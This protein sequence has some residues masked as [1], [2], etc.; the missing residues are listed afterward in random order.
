MVRSKVAAL[1]YAAAS[2]ELP[3]Y[4]HLDVATDDPEFWVILEAT[5]EDQLLPVHLELLEALEIPAPPQTQ[6]AAA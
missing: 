1:A 3:K 6:P 4:K 2:L 5:P